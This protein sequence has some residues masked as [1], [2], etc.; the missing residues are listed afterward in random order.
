M[1]Q[2]CPFCPSLPFCELIVENISVG[3]LYTSELFTN[4]LLDIVSRSKNK[5]VDSKTLLDNNSNIIINTDSIITIS[6][7]TNNY[8]DTMNTSNSGNTRNNSRNTDNKVIIGNNSK[9]DRANMSSPYANVTYV[10]DIDEHIEKLK[11]LIEVNDFKNKQEIF[12]DV[13]SF[14]KDINKPNSNSKTLTQA[15]KYISSKI[16]DIPEIAKDAAPL[17]K[18]ILEGL[19]SNHG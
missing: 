8:G 2:C 6:N 19:L 12:E 10:Q 1:V 13:E 9:V 4:K 18:T 3:A 15:F 16:K 7:I 11:N 14:S 5:I 17:I